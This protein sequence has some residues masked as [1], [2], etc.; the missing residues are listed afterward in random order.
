MALPDPNLQS[1]RKRS[2]TM[3]KNR[4]TN[5]DSNFD[6]LKNEKS[7]ENRSI[8]IEEVRKS[9]KIKNFNLEFSPRKR[10]SQRSQS[11]HDIGLEAPDFDASSAPHSPL[12]A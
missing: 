11:G 12:F 2:M 1:G 10:E 4:A 8:A 7:S 5:R 9:I 6:N 3:Q